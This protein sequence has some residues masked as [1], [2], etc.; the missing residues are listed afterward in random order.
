MPKLTDHKSLKG[1]A[2]RHSAENHKATTETLKHFLKIAQNARKKFKETPY[3]AR[4]KYQEGMLSYW[5]N[6]VSIIKWII[7]EHQNR[8]PK[9]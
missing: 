7:G 5:T 8:P 9:G 2:P 4:G 3:Q 6:G 1:T